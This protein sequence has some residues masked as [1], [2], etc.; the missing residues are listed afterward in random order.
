DLVEEAIEQFRPGTD[1]L[2][3]RLEGL[4]HPG[5]VGAADHGH[6]VVIVP[7]LGQV[8]PPALLAIL[9]RTDEIVALRFVLEITGSGWD[10]SGS[11]YQGDGENNL[12]PTTNAVHQP[13]EEARDERRSRGGRRFRVHRL[14]NASMPLSVRRGGL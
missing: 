7:E 5:L 9:V 4:F 8:L 11:K 1:A 3:Q 14:R 13:D 10:G 12:G 6:H 2:G